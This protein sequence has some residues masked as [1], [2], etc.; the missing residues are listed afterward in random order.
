LQQVLTANS[1]AA[2]TETRGFILKKVVLS[3]DR[4]RASLD[5]ARLRVALELQSDDKKQDD[6]DM[7]TLEF[8]SPVRVRTRGL[9]MKLVPTIAR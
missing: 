2:A 1:A 3:P 6:A 8:A 4:I 5:S 9:Q 7:A